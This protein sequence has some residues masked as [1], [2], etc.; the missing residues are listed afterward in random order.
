MRK[1]ARETLSKQIRLGDP[2]WVRHGHT[3]AILAMVEFVPDREPRGYSLPDDRLI[4]KIYPQGDLATETGHH[5][6][7]REVDSDFAEQHLVRQKYSRL[8]LKDGRFYSFQEIAFDLSEAYPL[9]WVMPERQPMV[10]AHV[11]QLVLAQWN[12]AEQKCRTR[13]RPARSYLLDEL[14][15]ALESDH[16]TYA[17]AKRV[18]LLDPA[19]P[20]ITI[21]GDDPARPLPNPVALASKTSML[22]MTELTFLVGFSHGDLHADNILAR[23]PADG[24]PLLQDTR[25]IDL[26]TFEPEASLSRDLATLILSLVREE[27]QRPMRPREDA[28]L[29]E[30]V[31]NPVSRTVTPQVAPYV[32]DAVRDVYSVQRTIQPNFQDLWHPQYLLSV[33]AQA[34]IHTSYDDVGPDGHW[35]YFRLAAHAAERFAS[36]RPGFPAPA[37]GVAQYIDRPDPA[38]A[39]NRSPAQ[40][41]QPAEVPVIGYPISVRDAFCTAL[42]PDL[43]AMAE[44]LDISGPLPD[45]RTLWDRAESECVLQRLAPAATRLGRRDLMDILT[46]THDPPETKQPVGR[47]MA[48][49]ITSLADRLVATVHRAATAT[50]ADELQV[51]SIAPTRLTAELC[52][53]LDAIAVPDTESEDYLEWRMEA[54]GQYRLTRSG[55]DRLA[56]LLPQNSTSARAGMHRTDLLIDT[57]EAARADLG[58][59]L[60]LL[61][62]DRTRD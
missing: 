54:R 30:F 45:A 20:W 44:L 6:L 42:G 28:K 34:L 22:G 46:M 16:D 38:P 31:L 47:S 10:A 29:I 26:A 24:E 57:A 23:V 15:G 3:G 60:N 14:R 62:D 43:T 11:A 8:P 53:L 2:P 49:E 13:K 50:S 55:L 25:L 51:Q 32:V 52:D 40:M 36:N 59:L 33:V 27:V 58:A 12:K 48:E 9:T 4:V 19:T 41:E 18:G 39:E 37:A 1:W 56:R 5:T 61:T 7:A 21:S 35:W 17:W